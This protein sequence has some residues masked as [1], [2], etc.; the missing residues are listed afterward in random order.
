[1]ERPQQ[2]VLPAADRAIAAAAVVFVVVGAAA[3][4]DVEQ[5]EDHAIARAPDPVAQV[6]VEIG[7][8][9]D[10]G[11]GGDDD[12]RPSPPPPP[13]ARVR[14]EPGITLTITEV[15]ASTITAAAATATATTR[16]RNDHFP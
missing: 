2:F 7:G 10:C 12:R 8:S 5:G 13:I 16:E 9:R 4:A 11:V 1:M 3:H 15:G 14:H 6:G